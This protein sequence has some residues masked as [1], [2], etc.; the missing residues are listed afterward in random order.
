M[1]PQPRFGEWHAKKIPLLKRLFL[2]PALSATACLAAAGAT[3][4]AAPV[5]SLFLALL[6]PIVMYVA[7]LWVANRRS[8]DFKTLFAPSVVNKNEIQLYG[9]LILHQGEL[10]Y[11][12]DE[13]LLVITETQYLFD[14][15]HCSFSGDLSH[16]P[17][18][19]ASMVKIRFGDSGQ[20]ARL[21]SLQL[22]VPGSIRTAKKF[23]AAI[24]SRRENPASE[25]RP[26]LMFTRL[27]WASA[28][29]NVLSG[30]LFWTFLIPMIWALL[31]LHDRA[32]VLVPAQPVE[33][34]RIMLAVG[35]CHLV[36]NLRRILKFRRALKL[37]TPS[38]S[39]EA[40]TSRRIELQPESE[41]V[42]HA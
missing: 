38:N 11:A 37:V 29:F 5:A 4:R 25:V 35:L 3:S 13:G 26:P 8:R 17:E 36:V 20:N 2:V 27:V 41:E 1:S 39:A 40:Q 32:M 23:F 31:P 15:Q 19:H 12:V 24:P 34:L 14:G 7:T 42:V 30:T 22:A 9:T 16:K 33:V 6:S 28:I 10:G 21:Y 18:Q